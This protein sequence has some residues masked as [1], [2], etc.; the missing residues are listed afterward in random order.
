MPW[1]ELNQTTPK[2]TLHTTGKLTWNTALQLRLGDP[3]WVDLMWNAETRQLGIRNVRSVTGLP[4]AAE[5]EQ[6]DYKI[7]SSDILTEA[8][9]SV[10]ENLVAEPETWQ[11]TNAGT[12]WD[13]WFGYNPIYH[14]TVPE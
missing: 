13:E 1:V 10:E 9:I 12:G 2:L 14:I 11:Q 7:D 6:S 5:P 3:K 8:G 4:V